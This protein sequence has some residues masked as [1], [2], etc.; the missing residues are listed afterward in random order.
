MPH[1]LIHDDDA[2]NLVLGYVLNLVVLLILTGS[3]TGVFY[4]YEDSSSQKS[5][6]TGFTDLGSQIARDITNMYLTSE[7]SPNSITLTVK[8]DI[9]LT[10]GGKGYWIELINASQNSNST[11]SVNIGEGTLN[12]PVITMINAVDNR[13]SASGIVSS[14]T[15]ELVITMKKDVSGVRVWLNSS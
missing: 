7:N 8:R 11:A 14:G 13:T 2:V 4:L 5:M 15:G 1:S 6:R 3:I 9:P 12:E 10:V